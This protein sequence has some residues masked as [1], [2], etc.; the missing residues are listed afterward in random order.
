M[1]YAILLVLLLAGCGPKPDTAMHIQSPATVPERV[2]E[3]PVQVTRIGVIPDELAYGNKRGIYRI[4]D[5]ETGKR[6]IGISGIG[7][8]E[9]GS[10]TESRGKTSQSVEDER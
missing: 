5:R 3:G 10:H 7:I 6:Y 2:V 4:Y 9:V 1:K 8:S